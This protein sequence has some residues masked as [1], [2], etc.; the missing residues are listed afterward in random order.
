MAQAEDSFC[1]PDA[2]TKQ[3]DENFNDFAYGGASTTKIEKDET[4]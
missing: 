2:S 4:K 1:A 3:V